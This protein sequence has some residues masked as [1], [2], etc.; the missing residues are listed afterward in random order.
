L[1]EIAKKAMVQPANYLAG[2]LAR[3][4]LRAISADEV[5]WQ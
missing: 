1:T 4:E 2:E 3:R 5:M